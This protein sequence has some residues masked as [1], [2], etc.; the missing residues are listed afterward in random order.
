MSNGTIIYIG[1]FELPDKNAAAHRVLSNGKVFRELG[2]N[3]VFID[4]DKSLSFESDILDTKKN[5][6]DFDCWSLPYPKSNKQWVKFLT[7]I[8]SIKLISSKYD[9][10]KA[11]VAY[12]YPAIALYKLRSYCRKNNI[13]IIADCTEWY[14]TRGSSVAFKIIKGLDSF[15]RMRI[16]QKRLDGLIVIS[17]FL[18]SYYKDHINTIRIPPLVDL[19]EKK[20]ES[21]NSK[22]RDT[23]LRM[24]Y[25]GSPGKN[26]DKINYIIEALYELDKYSNYVFNIVGITK[27]QY[28]NY[29]PE[30]KTKLSA[31]EERIVFLG[32]IS[33]FDSL[34][35]LK[36][37]DF[38]IF[39][40]EKSRLTMAG[41]PT[42]FV[43]SISCGIP[44]I[45]TDTSDI[46]EYF[47]DEKNGLFLDANSL[48]KMKEVFINLLD[49]DQ[50]IAE[51]KD[52]KFNKKVFHYENYVDKVSI[53]VQSTLN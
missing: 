22:T 37:S 12:N 28:I 53:F 25:S 14:S 19:D 44:V 38:S 39:I 27:E 52:R 2:Y 26:K 6:Q 13:R 31:L 21:N 36:N 7:D 48:G 42:K 10:V 29:Y 45:T 11:I 8:E 1:G 33:H 51:V 50:A 43:E 18:E 47:S 15:L 34:N 32:R 24:V 49:D 16:I 3:L 17:K 23:N 30:H 46:G 5:V 35:A 20:W 4:V 41:F 9:E 40:R